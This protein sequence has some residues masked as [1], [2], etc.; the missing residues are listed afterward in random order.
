MSLDAAELGGD[1]F[2]RGGRLEGPA[3]AG[4]RQAPPITA[5]DL[6]EHDREADMVWGA[7][8]A[9]RRSAVERLGGFDESIGGH[10]DEEEWL[11]GLRRSGGT[12]FDLRVCLPLLS[13]GTNGCRSFAAPAR[14]RL[15]RP[16]CRCHLEA[17]TKGARF[18]AS[19]S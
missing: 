8:F 4:W 18:S 13:A 7:N 3:P 10:G 19:A 15:G 17:Q 12:C 9:V 1:V 11:L 6:G 14:P 5:L 2:Q 16:G